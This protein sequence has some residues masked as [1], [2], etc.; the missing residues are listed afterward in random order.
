[1]KDIAQS[2]VIG[3]A[4]FVVGMTFSA[5]CE[6]DN[7]KRFVANTFAIP[8]GVPVSEYSPYA[9]SSSPQQQ[10]Q[11]NAPPRSAEDILLDRLSTLVAQKL[12]NRL[13]TIVRCLPREARQRRTRCAA[14]HHA[15]RAH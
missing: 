15:R 1:M 8:I 11:Y 2:F 13:R 7:H 6:A 3:I 4:I 9:Y 14:V 12:A 10:A 5:I